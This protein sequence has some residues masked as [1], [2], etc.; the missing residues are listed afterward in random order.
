MHFKELNLGNIFPSYY[1][2]YVNTFCFVNVHFLCAAMNSLL[3]L[4]LLVALLKSKV[5]VL[6]LFVEFITIHFLDLFVYVPIVS[7]SDLCQCHGI[8]EP[9]EELSIGAKVF[10]NANENLQQ[11]IDELYSSKNVLCETCGS[12]K[13]I[14]KKVLQLPDIFLISPIR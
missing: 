8:Q 1:F 11:A 6:I 10:I 13:Q 14:L 4:T 7:S 3:F 2:A 5:S 12:E 9:T